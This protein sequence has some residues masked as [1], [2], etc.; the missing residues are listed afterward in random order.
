MDGVQIQRLQALPFLGLPYC[1]PMPEFGPPCILVRVEGGTGERAG[2]RRPSASSY[3]T[4]EKWGA[5][6]IGALFSECS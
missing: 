4:C 3:R 5:H 6:G 2:L 1:D